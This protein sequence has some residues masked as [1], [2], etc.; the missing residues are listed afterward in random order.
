MSV[1]NPQ[2]DVIV[3]GA[4]ITGMYQVYLLHNAGLRVQGYEAG[5]DVGGTW[6]WNRYPGC[7]LDTE[8]YA[9][10]YFELKGI[11]PDWQWSERFASQPELLRYAKRAADTMGIR[12]AF[13]FNTRVEAA[14]FDELGNIWRL[15]LDDGS[16]TSCR[17]L[18]SAVGPLSATR[19]PNIPGIDSFQGVS[20]H[21][22]RWPRGEDEGPRD[23]DFTGKRVGIIGTGATGVQIIPIVAAQASKLHVFQRTANWCIPLANHALTPELIEELRGDPEAFVDFLKT[24]ETAFPYRRSRKKAIDATP[25]ERE[26]LFESLYPMPGYGLWLGAYRDLLTNKVS[27]DF[28]VEFVTRKIRE[29]VK[30]S[31][32]AEKLIP[33]DHAFGTR[34]VPMETNYYEIYNQDN[35][36][37]VDVRQT[38]IERVTPKGMQVGDREIE[39]DV[40]IYATGFDGVTGALDR[41]D[42]RGRGGIALKEAWADG[43]STYLGVQAR[44]FPN[45][46]TLVGAHNGASFC[47]IGVCGALQVEWVTE[48][49]VYMR[50][51]RLTSSE[52]VPHYE[53]DW[54]RHV[55]DVYAQTLLADTD[56]WWVRTTRNPDGSI[57]RRA[58][59][60]VGGAPD[61]RERCA[62]VAANGYEG[63]ALA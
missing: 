51:N 50:D 15:R 48:M 31:R 41:I 17:F 4:G 59:I 14:H 36:E 54:T 20:F 22:S 49:L 3:I 21:T 12:P 46:F 60:Y 40:L 43:P 27:N 53:E 63:F 10:G 19:M 25:L 39:L 13:R 32:I 56:A 45:F 30:D 42:I 55:Y 34:R 58:L 24:T 26:A 28:M 18:V 62:K 33:S 57:R 29:R 6:Y 47:N 35:V 44:G 37:L 61:Y 8:S 1:Q 38:P 16:E 2:H 9:Y 23:V 11:L 5:S 7:R 52:P